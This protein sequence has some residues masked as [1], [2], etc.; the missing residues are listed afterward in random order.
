MRLRLV[1]GEWGWG[2]IVVVADEM[3]RGRV[4]V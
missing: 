2:F 3:K 4:M 1:R